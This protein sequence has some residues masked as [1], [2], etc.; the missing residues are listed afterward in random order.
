MK[1]KVA[2]STLIA[3]PVAAVLF[4]TVATASLNFPAPGTSSQVAKAVAASTSITTLT[5][6]VADEVYNSP[7]DN[8]A[9]DYPQ[10]RN[11]CA[12][13]SSCVFGDKKSSKKLVIMGDSHAQMWIPALNRIGN[14]LKMKV[15]V[16][17]LARCPAASLNVWLAVYDASYTLC[18]TTRTK[19]IT[20]INKMHPVTVLLSD[21][22]NAV[23]TAASNGA[24]LFTSAQ[25][26]VG[27]ETT[28]TDLHASKAKI[29]V[30]GDFITFDQAPPQCLATYPT[31]VQKCASPNPNPDRPNLESAEVAAAKAKK[32]LYVDPTKW[33]CTTTSCSPVIGTYIAYYD[34]FHLS[35]TYAAYLSGVLQSSLK[36]VL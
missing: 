28:I 22:T 10:T 4:A 31:Q 14:S 33:L 30:L 13:A 25:W 36:K 21:H 11:G 12:T 3:I 24:Q 17:F 18:T 16:L 15:I 6:K 9:I 29:A 23:Y 32:V 19:W 1:K 34:A 2:W 8:P 26:Q 27:E 5:K 20:A 35:C 7:N